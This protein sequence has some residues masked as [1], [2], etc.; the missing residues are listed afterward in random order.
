VTAARARRGADPARAR[1]TL[2][3][4]PGSRGGAALER[5][6]DGGL[7]AKVTAPPAEGRA[8]RAVEELLS[9]VLGVPRRCVSVVRGASSR[10]KVVEIEG[11]G[12]EALRARLEAALGGPSTLLAAAAGARRKREER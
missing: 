5:G 12:A 2:R 3:V 11:L 8:N 1:I 6:A 7:R 9:E 4:Q 10:T